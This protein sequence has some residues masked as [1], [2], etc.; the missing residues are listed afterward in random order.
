MVYKIDFDNNLCFWVSDL[1][2]LEGKEVLF[3]VALAL[4]NQHKE[5]ILRCDSFEQ[6]MIYLKTTLPQIDKPTMDKLL[7][8]VM[9]FICLYKG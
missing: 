4:L 3:R 2:F 8:E 9:N 7:K 1:L 6:I 5:G